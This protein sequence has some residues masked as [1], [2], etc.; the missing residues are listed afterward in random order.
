MIISHGLETTVAEYEALPTREQKKISKKFIDL[1]EKSPLYVMTDHD[2]LIIAHA[3]I[4]KDYIG[5][6]NKKVKTFVLYG[7]ISG[8]KHPDGSPVR[9]DWAQDYDGEAWIV[10]GHTPV[11]EA[12]QVQSYVQ[13]RYRLCF[14]WKANSTSL[15]RI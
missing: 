9:R 11:K 10:Y 3:G 14:W 15:S 6:T 7:D 5:K 8:A 12:R 4:R 13:Y 2:K 1:Y